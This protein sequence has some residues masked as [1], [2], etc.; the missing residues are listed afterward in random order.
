[1]AT[2]QS[3]G[4]ASSD[5]GVDVTQMDV[6]SSTEA[7]ALEEVSFTTDVVGDS[8]SFDEAA[9]RSKVA[10]ELG[11]LPSDVVVNVV[12]SGNPFSVATSVVPPSATVAGSMKAKLDTIRSSGSASTAFGVSVPTGMGASSTAAATPK[13]VSFDMT[14]SGDSTSFDEAAY[15]TKVAAELGVR[16]AAIVLSVGSGDP[17]V[18]T[19]SVTVMSEQQSSSVVGTLD[20][21]RSSGSASTAFGVP[22]ATSIGAAASGAGAPEVVTF[23][24]TIAG[25][26]TSFNE[27]AYRSKVAVEVICQARTLNLFHVT[28]LSAFF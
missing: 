5:F 20:T 16:E 11:V 7:A 17:F 15:R 25:D 21:I 1:L 19:A 6:P 22:D 9:Y 12:G 10:A 3:S 28:F 27:V 4:T 14:V 18:V 24:A 2:I 13:A 23:A 26:A 8:T